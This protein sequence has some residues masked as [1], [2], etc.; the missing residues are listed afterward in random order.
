[1]ENNPSLI[2]KSV[3]QEKRVKFLDTVAE[4]A[5]RYTFANTSNYKVM[6]DSYY[7]MG[8]VY[9]Y[10]IILNINKVWTL[11][12]YHDE[13]IPKVLVPTKTNITD[14]F[15]ALKYDLQF[16]NAQELVTCD[17]INEAVEK[18]IN[19]AETDFHF[20][21]IIKEKL[22]MEE[23]QVVR[24]LNSPL[25]KNYLNLQLSRLINNINSMDDELLVKSL[26]TLLKRLRLYI[27][28][29]TD[30]NARNYT[31]EL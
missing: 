15:R 12:D 8:N 1:M 26:N 29:S 4:D 31:H 9:L 27:R 19:N 23:N 20:K 25:I 10:Q 2:Y 21:N 13:N 16:S 3:E 11:L 30:I 28:D 14:L 18:V 5:P 7:A 6:Q 22:Y 17:D 24:R